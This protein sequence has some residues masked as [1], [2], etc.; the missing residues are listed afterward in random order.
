MKANPPE[1]LPYD[2]N[3]AIVWQKLS[4]DDSWTSYT[5]DL[6]ADNPTGKLVIS[7]DYKRWSW[8]KRGVDAGD[9][10]AF[11][12]YMLMSQQGWHE[13]LFGAAQQMHEHWQ[14]S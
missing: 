12:A 11:T 3:I 9:T 13:P 14:R 6:D 10:L 4:L 5:G 2:L 1:L 8:P 7:R